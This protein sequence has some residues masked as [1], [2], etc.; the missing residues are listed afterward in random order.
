MGFSGIIRG[1][2]ETGMGLAKGDG[3]QIVSGLGRTVKSTVT[4]VISTIAGDVIEAIHNDDDHD[5]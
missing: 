4:T 5:D 3:E 2:I 1:V